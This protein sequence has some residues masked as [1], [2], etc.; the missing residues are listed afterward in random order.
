M[1]DFPDVP[2]FRELGYDFVHESQ[3]LMMAP[4]GTPEA[5]VKKLDDALRKALDDQEVIDLYTKLGVAPSYRG[6][7]ELAKYLPESREKVGKIVKELGITI[8]PEKK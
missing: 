6:H 5:V 3:S 4:K 7:E 8:Q 1:K 2:T